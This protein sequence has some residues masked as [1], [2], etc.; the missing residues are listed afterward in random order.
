[1]ASCRGREEKLGIYKS[2]GLRGGGESLPAKPLF[3]VDFE[4]LS[5]MVLADQNKVMNCLE[6][7]VC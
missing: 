2:L 1:M 6:Q 3:L 5:L 4:L 7:S